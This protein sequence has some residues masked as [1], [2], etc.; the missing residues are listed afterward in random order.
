[1]GARQDFVRESF[2]VDGASQNQG[3]NYPH[4]Y[5]NRFPARLVFL[6]SFRRQFLG[7]RRYC[8]FDVLRERQPGARVTG[9]FTR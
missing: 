4:Q 7:D 1:M 5:S 8:V 3:A 2:V 9:D 6:A